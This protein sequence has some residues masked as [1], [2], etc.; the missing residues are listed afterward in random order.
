LA[1]EETGVGLAYVSTEIINEFFEHMEFSAKLLDYF[2]WNNNSTSINQSEITEGTKC[3]RQACLLYWKT[4]VPEYCIATN[5][6]CTGAGLI[7]TA[8]RLH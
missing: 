1:K 2:L 8:I 3:S 4:A 7:C 5:Y 6:N